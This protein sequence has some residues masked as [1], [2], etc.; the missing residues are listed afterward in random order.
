[1]SESGFYRRAG[2]EIIKWVVL[3]TIL[4][5]IIGVIGWT[6]GWIA[7]PFRVVNPEAAVYNWQWYYD[8]HASLQ[9][10]TDTIHQY[11]GRL[12]DFSETYGNPSTWDWQT[13]EEHQRLTSVIDGYIA[14][15]NRVASE[16]NASIRDITRRWARPRDLPECIS[17]WGAEHC[18]YATK[19]E[20]H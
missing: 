20:V 9:A 3:S 11:E 18:T 6:A 12:A 4:C 14:N 10:Q 15:Y 19:Y 1:M 8:T 17:N 13:K 16:Y 2:G 7:L 5:L